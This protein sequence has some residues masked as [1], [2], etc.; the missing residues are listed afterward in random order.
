MSFA[1]SGVLSPKSLN[2]TSPSSYSQ[3][4]LCLS[5]SGPTVSTHV[6]LMAGSPVQDRPFRAMFQ[7]V[8]AVTASLQEAGNVAV[9]VRVVDDVARYVPSLR[10][11]NVPSTS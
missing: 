2:T 11:A 1:P 5:G 9:A 6:Q 4:P 3:Y 10:I 8:H 7:S